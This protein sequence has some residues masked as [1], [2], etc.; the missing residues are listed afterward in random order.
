MSHER[1]TLR[2]LVPSN[3]PAPL[4]AYSHGV[5]IPTGSDLVVC[6]GQL[7]IG[8]DQAVPGTVEEQARRCFSNAETILDAAGMTL[9]DVVRINAFVTAREHLA[10][11]MAV[12]DELFP[13]PAPASTLMIVA[14]FTREEFLVEVEVLAARAH[15]NPPSTGRPR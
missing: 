3:M 13:E 2:H 8:S 14:G 10:G 4:A 11:Y 1:R 5:I 9:A 12:R 7:G 15:G 6:S